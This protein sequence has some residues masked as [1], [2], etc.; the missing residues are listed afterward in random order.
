[1]KTFFVAAAA[2]ALIAMA[3]SGM[4]DT[5]TLTVTASV[6]GTCKF[7]AGTSLLGFGSL[8]PSVG[9]DVNASATT[10]FWCTKGVTTDAVSA[11]TGLNFAGGKRGMKD[12]VSGDVIP[13]TL[14]LTKDANPNAG[15][16][17]PRILTLAGGVLGADY[18]AKTAGSYSDT[19]VV[20]INP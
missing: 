11:N 14:T 6:A 10:Q 15:P 16:S 12:T 4:A 3:G 2:I 20:S 13:Y 1:M 17:A 7:V 5:N 9:T 19:V 8:D 18:T